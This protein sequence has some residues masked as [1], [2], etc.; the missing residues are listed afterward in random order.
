MNDSM[1]SFTHQNDKSRGGVYLLVN[2]TNVN[3]IEIYN[4]R[5]LSGCHVYNRVQFEEI[6]EIKVAIDWALGVKWRMNKKLVIPENSN[7]S[8]V[9]LTIHN[10]KLFLDDL[11]TVVIERR[12]YLYRNASEFFY[13]H[14]RTTLSMIKE[15]LSIPYDEDLLIQLGRI[16]QR[17]NY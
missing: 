5:S 15:T 6:E 7:F 13:Q 1:L 2:C 8:S 14:R 3:K 10:P 11:E 12:L 9:R 16:K 17:F 4:F